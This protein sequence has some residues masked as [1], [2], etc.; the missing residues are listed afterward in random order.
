MR[1]LLRTLIAIALVP[2]LAGCPGPRTGR[3]TGYVPLKNPGHYQ[4]KAVSAQGNV[5][6]LSVRPNEHAS[7]DLEFWSTAIEHQKVDL[8]GLKLVARESV[9]NKSGQDGTFF[10][11]ETGEGQGKLAYLI[12]LYVTPLKVFTFE[13]AGG[14]AAID[15]DM[16]KLKTAM[17]EGA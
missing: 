5:L 14:A 7:G 15:K 6:A 1:T 8:D 9:K 17:T 4:W 2:V 3:I 11:F 12:T 13:A 16:A 10:H